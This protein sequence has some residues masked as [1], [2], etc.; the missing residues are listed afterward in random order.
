M[1]IFGPDALQSWNREVGQRR[2][3]AR[4]VVL[5]GYDGFSAQGS[6]GQTLIVFPKRHVVAVRFTQEFDDYLKVEFPQFPD[7]V[8]AL[9]AEE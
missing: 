5:S 2:F 1:R 9:V 8:R 4:T 7:L 3:D 6:F